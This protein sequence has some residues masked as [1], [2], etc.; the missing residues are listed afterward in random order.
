M[1]EKYFVKSRKRAARD[2][3]LLQARRDEKNLGLSHK[4]KLQTK[5]MQYLLRQGFSYDDVR[6]VIKDEV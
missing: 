1:S 2:L 5:R 4:A 3:D 6:S